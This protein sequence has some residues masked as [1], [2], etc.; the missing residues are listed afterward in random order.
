MHRFGDKRSVAYLYHT[1]IV[2]AR[3]LTLYRE[4][5]YYRES[6]AARIVREV[7]RLFPAR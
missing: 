6:E 5:G 4:R 7:E 3:S 1:A 2:A